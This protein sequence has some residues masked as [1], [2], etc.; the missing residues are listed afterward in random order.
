MNADIEYKIDDLNGI[1]KDMETLNEFCD[2]LHGSGIDSEW[3]YSESA[4]MHKLSNSYHCMN[5]GG[6]YDGCIDFTIKF[7]KTDLNDYTLVLNGSHS[8]NKNRKYQLN[9]Y[10]NDCIFFTLDSIR[11]GE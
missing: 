1:I 4:K 2:K 5:D 10:L 9:E 3:I 8:H 11:L 6:Y 7:N